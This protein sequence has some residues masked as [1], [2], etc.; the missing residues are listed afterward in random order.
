MVGEKYDFS[1]T[2]TTAQA[3]NTDVAHRAYFIQMF[4]NIPLRQHLTN[5]EPEARM[6]FGLLHTMSHLFLSGVLHFYVD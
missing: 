6:V 3:T 4:N 1:P 5:E 2:L